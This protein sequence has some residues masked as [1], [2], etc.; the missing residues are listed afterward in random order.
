MKKIGILGGGQLGRMTIEEARALLCHIEVLSPEYP[1]PAADLADETLI[2]DLM[3]R[4]AVLELADRVDVLSY[5]IEHV[6]VAALYEVE[7][8]G[9]PVIPGAGV[10]A[11]IQDKVAQKRL[12]DEAGIPTAPWALIGNGEEPA[13][14]AGLMAA[15]ARLPDGTDVS[16]GFPVV[17][18]ARRGGYDGRGVAV[19]RNR[20]DAASQADVAGQADAA[21]PAV[22]GRLLVAPGFVETQVDFAKELAVVVVRDLAGNTAAYPC[23]EMVFDPRVNLCDSVLMPADEPEA[24]RFEAER[25]ALEAVAALDAAARRDAAGRGSATAGAAG[26]F[27]VELFLTKDGALLVNEIAPRPHNSGHVTMEACATSQFMQYYRILA[28]YPLGSTEMLRPAMM[29]NLLG[30]AGADGEPVYG[31]L[32]QA[33]GVP[34]VSVHLYGKRQVRPFRKMGHLTALASTAAEARRLAMNAREKL[35]ITALRG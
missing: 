6:N 32:E 20:A 4:D 25:L 26:V 9:K 35:R 28:G 12:M 23:V 15:A 24:V 3:D 34:G 1:A 14:S 8:G 19:I 31:G 29:V 13:T 33:L 7:A 18:K 22:G 27:G 10:L 16:G 30:E 11:I 21:P 5:E 17:Q 2:G